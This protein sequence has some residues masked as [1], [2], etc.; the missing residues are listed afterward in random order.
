MS[1][2]VFIDKYRNIG[3]M[4]HIDAGKTTFTERVL[5]FTGKSHKIGEVHDG[6]ATMD[7]MIQEQERGITITSAA[8]T[9]FWSLNDVKH[10][11]NIIDTPGHVDFTIE[12]ERSLRVLDG[13]VTVFD[14]VAGVEPQSETVWRQAN[15]YRV[16]RICFVNKLDRQGANFDRC[17]NMIRDRLR[18]TP[19][20]LQ[21]PVGSESDFV[22]MIDLIAMK[23]YKWGGLDAK[24]EMFEIL[25]IPSDMLNEAKKKRH[26]MV[27]AIAEYDDECMDKYFAD[28]DL[29]ND[30]IVKCIRIGT[31]KMAISPVLCGSA[32]KNKGV[33]QVLD[34]VVMYLPSPVDVPRDKIF[35]NDAE[36][37][38]SSD[39]DNLCDL[40]FCGL[41][42]KVTNDQFG[43]LTYIR[44]YSGKISSGMK[45]LNSS[46]GDEERIGRLVLLHANSREDVNSASA[47]D[48]VAAIGL[49]KS[50]T[51]HT[52]CDISNPLLLES[53]E[54][55][56]GVIEQKITPMSDADQTKMSDGLSKL[57]AE[58]PSLSVKSDGS[59]TVIVGMGELHLDI[60]VD[61]LK[62][63]FG[64]E[65][66]ISS[67]KVSY[68]ETI[69][70]S[71]TKEYLHKKQTGG[72]GQY[73]KL[74]IV[75]SP[76]SDD[77]FVFVDKIVGGV[78]P[79][80]YIASVEK[81]IVE[82]M[83]NGRLLGYPVVNIK[84]ELIDGDTHSVDSSANAFQ[85]AA[86]YAF[87]EAMEESGMILLEPIMNVEVTTPDEFVG[88]VMGDLSSRR[89]II[90]SNSS[91]YA[92][93]SVVFAR[94]PLSEM[95]GYI[96]Q[97]RGMT[98]GRASYSMTFADYSKT[99]EGVLVKLREA[100]D[101][102]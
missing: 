31:L 10:R 91:P 33:Q 71:V 62:R 42:F 24:G 52:L 100:V 63:E 102:K 5:Y 45:V 8:T 67:P 34:A 87:K 49:R 86:R 17:V 37:Y 38:L 40:P 26:E 85:I 36:K 97:L 23:F 51:G 84:V 19:V 78:I 59:G 15:K 43:V 76:T 72:A 22:G 69:V 83:E 61:R 98:Q 58:D 50:S 82:A 30:D 55:M 79:K 80:E 94:V 1:N 16:P 95:F 7:W 57:L 96:T 46:T 89:G 9:C 12:V 47:G 14:G 44:I 93:V 18:M 35:P 64:C 21:M 4:A 39:R 3:I 6:K 92:G 99:P 29:S 81:G 32:L 88:S 101:T 54:K 66:K 25:D 65:V 53:I 60:I 56:Q 41:V 75:V 11:I 77:E 90:S 48:I 70:N 68:K 74:T 2:N 27:D 20:P 73:A 28:G 13:A